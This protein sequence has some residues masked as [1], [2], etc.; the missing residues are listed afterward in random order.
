MEVKL[1]LWCSKEKNT[2]KMSL[3]LEA[4]S[5]LVW[6]HS[7][8][9]PVNSLHRDDFCSQKLFR[10]KLLILN[11]IV[12]H[13]EHQIR[14]H[15]S[16]LCSGGDRYLLSALMTVLYFMCSLTK[17][18]R[19]HQMMLDYYCKNYSPQREKGSC[20]SHEK[21]IIC[22]RCDTWHVES[23]RKVVRLLVNCR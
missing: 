8:S 9:A 7:H 20:V 6:I 12:Q 2:L 13:F 18:I 23:D 5:L 10:W 4:E 1:S 11:V 19:K 14:K 3:I 15:F 16:P 17:I 22:R 21:P